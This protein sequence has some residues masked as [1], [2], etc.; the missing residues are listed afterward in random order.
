MATRILSRELIYPGDV[1][2][3]SISV[4]D[5]DDLETPVDPAGL[6]VRVKS[7]SGTDDTYTYGTDAELIRSDVGSYYIDIVTDDSGDWFVNMKSTT[8]TDVEEQWFK[9][10]ESVFC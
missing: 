8:P 1:V 4:V 7:N 10:E 5:P 6:V 9:V 3:M 2:R